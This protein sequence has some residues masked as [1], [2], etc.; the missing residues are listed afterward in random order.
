M[1]APDFA[2][3]HLLAQVL[4]SLFGPLHKASLRSITELVWSLLLCQSLHPSDLAR[5][6]P[7]LRTARA[8]QALR[9]VR[10][11]LRRNYLTSEYLTPF[12]IKVV[13]SLVTNTEA[14][15]ILDS[16]RC[17]R[18]EIFTLGI[19]LYGRVLPI[20]W[21]ILPYPWPKRSFTPTVVKLIHRIMSCWPTDRAVHLLADRGFPSL[22]FFR[23]L[24]FWRKSLC[25]G[26]TIRLRAGDWIC[27]ESGQKVKL[28]DLMQGVTT[29]SWAGISAGYRH[30]GKASQSALLVVGRGVPVYPAHQRG[31][32]DEARRRKKANRRIAHLLSKK[33][34][35]SPDTDTIW[36]LMSTEGNCAE[37]VKKYSLRFST[38]GTYRDLKSW[39]LEEVAS[40][41]TDIE[42]LGGLMGVAALGYIAQAAIG[43]VAGRAVD[44]TARAR[45]QQWSTADRLSVFWR[46]RQVLHDRAHDWRGWLS[47]TLKELASQ[48]NSISLTLEQAGT[49][50]A[51]QQ[52]KEA[53]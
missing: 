32:A 36:A 3:Y 27:L 19:K 10:R 20:A 17:F 48:L 11:I 41:E 44:D 37:A 38:E 52:Q 2:L 4:Q 31:A 45:Q 15:L 23:E 35:N 25:L 29:G 24:D 42:H 22:K 46:G 33:Q 8:R 30:R 16:T 39:G 1:C 14:M 47:E 9:R 13:L 49:S 50:L 18:W 43:S 53:A 7:E 26:Y 5:A 6:L 40:H 21:S 12:L 34:A 28:A 51:T